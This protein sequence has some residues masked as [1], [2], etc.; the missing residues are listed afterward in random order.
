MEIADKEDQ[1]RVAK[2]LVA[3]WVKDWTCMVLYQALTGK[4]KIEKEVVDTLCE[5]YKFLPAD[6]FWYQG[7]KGVRKYVADLNKR[8][9]DALWDT[10]DNAKKLSFA[11][12][13]ITLDGIGIKSTSKYSREDM[14]LHKSDRKKF[15][16]TFTRGAAKE[17]SQ[18]MNG[19]HWGTVK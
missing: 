13:I 1:L 18:K 8:L 19:T 6:W 11:S 7:A 16:G 2:M 14:N 17:Y 9:S 5:K 15:R 4:R 10:E 12:Y 3:A